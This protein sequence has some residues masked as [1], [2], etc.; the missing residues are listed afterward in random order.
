MEAC[1]DKDHAL[2]EKLLLKIKKQ[3]KKEYGIDP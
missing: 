1:N 2:E 3:G